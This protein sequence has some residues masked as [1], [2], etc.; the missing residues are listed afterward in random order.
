M[1]RL[2]ILNGPPSSGKDSIVKAVVE[3]NP[4]DFNHVEFKAKL[5]QITKVIYD[6]SDERWDE[7]YTT[8]GKEQ[9]L[10][11]L[12]GLSPRQ[13][14]IKVSEEVIKPNFGN[15]YF[16]K[17]LVRATK[18][19]MINLCSDG[20]FLEELKPCVEKLG[21][22]NVLLIQLFR[23]GCTFEG[24]SRNYINDVDTVRTTELENNDTLER[25]ISAFKFIMFC[26][27]MSILLNE[28]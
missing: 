11:E 23:D 4:E 28:A 26:D 3:Q 27:G 16:G 22:D 18:P 15:D 7:V 12:E 21:Y 9:P 6:I 20:G 14:L 25:A 19:N 8:V 13:A 1:S 24:D 2:V 5:I 10:E 17:S